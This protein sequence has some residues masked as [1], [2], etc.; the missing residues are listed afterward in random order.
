MPAPQR[1]E[2][3]WVEFSPGRGS[4]QQGRR[5]GLVIQNDVGNQYS[6]TTVVVAITT[7]LPTRPFPF[8]VVLAAGEG[9]L[10]QASALNCSQLMTISIDRLEGRIGTLSSERLSQI[11]AA[12][13]YELAL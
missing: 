7:T 13:R 9:G 1:G 3:Y 5:P 8:V 10:P 6:R 11:D 12:L 4:E 2:I